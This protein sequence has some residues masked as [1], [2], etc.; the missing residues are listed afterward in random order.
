MERLLSSQQPNYK[1][2][3]VT[4]RPNPV[5]CTQ[6]MP[7]EEAASQ[8]SGCQQ[9]DTL[10]SCR[11]RVILSFFR[12]LVTTDL[13]LGMASSFSLYLPLPGFSGVFPH[14]LSYSCL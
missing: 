13:L 14:G 7:C 12:L 2:G 4:E 1:E 6:G 9:P 8:G 11:G 10:Q 3:T 5:V